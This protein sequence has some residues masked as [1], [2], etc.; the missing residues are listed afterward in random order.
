M[1]SSERSRRGRRRRPRNPSRSSSSKSGCHSSSQQGREHERCRGRP[2]LRDVELDDGGDDELRGGTMRSAS[3][4]SLGTVSFLRAWGRRARAALGKSSGF[5]GGEDKDERRRPGKA[6][7][8]GSERWRAASGGRRRAFRR[9]WRH[10]LL[11]V[12]SL[13]LA[14]PAN[15]DDP[16]YADCPSNT[17][18]TRGSAFQVNLDAL[19]SSLPGAAAASSGYAENV[20][21]T[22]PDQACTCRGDVNASDCRAC[23]DAAVRDMATKCTAGE[24]SAML[25]YEACL[26][27]HSNA[28]FFGALDTSLMVW[29]SNTPNTTQP[30]RFTWTLGTLMTDLKAKAAYASPRMFAVGSAALTPSLNIYGMVQCTRD[31]VADDCNR[32]LA[33]AFDAIPTY[34][35]EKQVGRIVY[36]S[37]S[38]RFETYPFYNIRAAEAAMSPVPSPGGGPIN[39]S[40]HFVAGSTGESKF[41]GLLNPVP[42]PTRSGSNRTV[43]TALLVSI[44]AAV[45]LLVVLTVALYLRKRIRKPLRHAQMATIRHGADKEMSCSSQLLLY[46]LSTLRAAT[47]NFSEENKLGEGGFGP[48]YKEIAVKRL[49]AN[50]QQGLVEM[51]NEVVLVAKL[52]HRNLVRLLGCCIEKHEKLLV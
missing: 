41:S 4:G 20:V 10:L 43:R 29:L 49:S 2:R 48:V 38:V 1:E 33:T 24:K 37:C 51:K 5:G 31:L 17:N 34:N 7:R 30:A 25:V 46:D 16:I 45:S 8:S 47:D 28:N 3:S 44:P 36:R 52:Q 27:R 39:G 32:C 14:A 12:C 26:L 15:A 35:N 22:A 42:F 21:G 19:L 40:D 11:L 6:S 9:S 23:L 18:Y 13:I 50:S